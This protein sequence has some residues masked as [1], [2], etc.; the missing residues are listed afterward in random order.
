MRNSG[1]ENTLVRAAWSAQNFSEGYLRE[2]ALSGVV[3]RPAASIRE[4]IIDVDDIADVAVAALIVKGHNGQLYEVT[5]PRLMSFDEIASALSVA[6]GSSVHYQ[7]ITLEAFHAK[8]K[9]I[10][11][12]LI[13]DVL[14]VVCHETLD[15]RNEWV[16][17]GFQPALGR[18]PR[19]FVDSC[20]ATADA[21]WDS[22]ENCSSRLI[23]SS[24]VCVSWWPRSPVVPALSAFSLVLSIRPSSRSR[25]IPIRRSWS[26]AACIISVFAL[27]EDAIR[28]V[29]DCMLSAEMDA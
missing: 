26:P 11:G 28:S 15:G 25:R 8:M 2:P 18:Q 13:A 7:A 23:I 14:K 3:A 10:G 21:E 1:L 22:T 29:I 9:T 20:Q 12:E 24:A 4:P 16:G 27:D 5:G 17:D 19:E 6:M